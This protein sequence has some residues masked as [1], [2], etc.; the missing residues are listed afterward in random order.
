MVGV[1]SLNY[2]AVVYAGSR[3]PMP[4]LDKAREAGLQALFE[5]GPMLPSVVDALATRYRLDRTLTRYLR[6]HV[7]DADYN[8]GLPF[9][10]STFGIIL[11]QGSLKWDDAKLLPDADVP[12]P[13]YVRF[14]CDELFRV[15]RTGG[16]ALVS[17]AQTRQAGYSWPWGSS[18][19]LG[20]RTDPFVVREALTE[21]THSRI[22]TLL[23]KAWLAERGARPLVL[24]AS[25]FRVLSVGER[26]WLRQAR[27]AGVLPLELVV[28]AVASNATAGCSPTKCTERLPKSCQRKP[29]RVHGVRGGEGD[30]GDDDAL[31]R[32]R[33]PYQRSCAVAFMHG[34]RTLGGL[35]IHKFEPAARTGAIERFSSRCV[36]AAKE[37]PLLRPPDP[38]RVS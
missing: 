13:D 34:T 29:G 15:L 30:G 12:T 37:L 18:A 14:F 20:N 25:T 28:G 6:P 10:S 1:T 33:H 5:Q 4:P 3:M 23:A 7:A 9:E 24:P 16:T 36:R 22:A 31:T 19:M 27:D 11:E 2:T 38:P 26:D 35:Y 21:A 17:I 32:A 8:R